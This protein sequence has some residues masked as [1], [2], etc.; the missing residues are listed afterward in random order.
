MFCYKQEFM[1]YFT[2][3]GGAKVGKHVSNQT[4]NPTDRHTG[5][6]TDEH[7]DEHTDEHTDEHPDEHTYPGGPDPGGP[8]PG[9]L[10][11]PAPGGPD[12]LSKPSGGTVDVTGKAVEVDVTGDIDV[13]DHCAHEPHVQQ[14]V[15]CECIHE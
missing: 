10:D 8:D 3:L 13:L 1:F 4:E 5:E 14:E 7:I 9:D 12:V 15:N 6:L 2:G 11:G